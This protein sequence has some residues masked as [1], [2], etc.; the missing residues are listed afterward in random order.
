M[1]NNEYI[2]KSVRL[3]PY[4]RVTKYFIEGERGFVWTYRDETRTLNSL[5]SYY[6]LG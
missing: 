5:S 1:K 3:S 2:D 4:Y 6:K